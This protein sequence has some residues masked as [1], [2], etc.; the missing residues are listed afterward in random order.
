MGKNAQL[1]ANPDMNQTFLIPKALMDDADASIT[2]ILDRDSYDYV[3]SE[4]RKLV[5][6]TIAPLKTTGIFLDSF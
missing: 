2:S 4:L 1:E 5:P 6:A 3:Y